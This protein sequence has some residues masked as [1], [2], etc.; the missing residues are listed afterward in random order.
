MAT[1]TTWAPPWGSGRLGD[2][3]E[4]SRALALALQVA[5]YGELAAEREAARPHSRDVTWRDDGTRALFAGL[6]VFEVAHDAMIARRALAGR[7]LATMT[8]PV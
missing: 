3:A 2:E 5:L 4:A 7:L 8:G 1:S 6:G